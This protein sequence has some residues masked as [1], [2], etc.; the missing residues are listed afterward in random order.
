[1][2]VNRK[3]ACYLKN[4]ILC[5]NCRMNGLPEVHPAGCLI[6]LKIRKHNNLYIKLIFPDDQYHEMLNIT[7]S[8]EERI[9]GKKCSGLLS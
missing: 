1:S 2:P 7:C 4:F 9:Y 6:S 3:N 8:L 5:K